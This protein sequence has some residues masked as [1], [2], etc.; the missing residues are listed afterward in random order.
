MEGEYPCIRQDG[1]VLRELGVG[2]QQ[3]NAAHGYRRE[4]SW[5]R[6]DSGHIE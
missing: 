3:R 5:P 4:E 1:V 2:S 6:P